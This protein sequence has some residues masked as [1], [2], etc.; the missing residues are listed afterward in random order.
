MTLVFRQNQWIV[1]ICSTKNS[2]LCKSFGNT[3]LERKITMS[4][5]HILMTSSAIRH[6]I[7]ATNS[8]L[9]FTH[10]NQLS[11][12]YYVTI[13]FRRSLTTSLTLNCSVQAIDRQFLYCTLES[14]CGYTF[15]LGVPFKQRFTNAEHLKKDKKK[16]AKS[17]I[18]QSVL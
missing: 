5:V 16:V 18:Q 4:S 11:L 7:F 10:F 6:C 14:T 1:G 8:F 2:S 13:S 3:R 9:C 12:M 15:P 17:V